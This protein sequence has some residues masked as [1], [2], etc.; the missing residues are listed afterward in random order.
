[1]RTVGL[2]V[3]IA[4]A[5]GGCAGRSPQPVAVVQAQDRYSDCTAIAAEIE[6][7]NQELA[8][9]QGLK[10]GQNVA[11][12]VAGLVVWPLLFAMDFRDSAS[13]EV[14]ALQSRQQYLAT[15]AKQRCAPAPP[16]QAAAVRK[17]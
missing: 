1:M 10:V 2:A 13:K 17:R 15:L 7:N 8:S 3:G 16:P 11:A 5:V 9:E 6:A 4:V 14:A 12:G